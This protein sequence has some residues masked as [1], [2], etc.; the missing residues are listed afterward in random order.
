MDI[1]KKHGTL[2]KFPIFHNGTG[3]ASVIDLGSNSVK[4]V[5]YN[6]DS[7][8]SYKPYH[9]ESV[10][11][12][13][14]EGLVDGKIQEKYIENTI[15]T[16]KLFRNIVDFEQIDYLIA[17]ATSAV[18]DAKNRLEFLKRIK[19][20]TNFDFKILSE[21]EEALYSYTGAIRS[22]NLPSVVFFDIGGGSLE[23]VSSKNFEIQKVI[24]L[25]LGSL[26]LTQQFSNKSE[27][28][29][30]SI[31]KMKEYIVNLLPSRESLGILDYKDVIL[32]G[33][34]G[35][36]RAL[37]KYAQAKINY[38]LTKLHN[39]HLSFES[40]DAI[41]KE[42]LLQTNEK[43]TK[44][45]SIGSA[46]S[47]TIKAGSMIVSELMKKLEFSS[48][49]VSAQGLREGTLS[50]S[51]QYPE[52]FS[53]HNIER[54]HIQELIYLSCQPD[55]LS[56]HVEDLVHIFFSMNILSEHERIL[57]AQSIIQ[58]DN[59][60]SFRDVDNVLYTI[61]DNDSVLSHKEQLIVALSLIYSKKK[62]KAELLIT[63]FGNIL[64]QSDKKTI[65]KISTI[66]SLCDIF[67]KT[68]TLVKPKL[69]AF[70]S[71]HL[72]VFASKNTFPEILLKQACKKIENSLGI[73]IITS[74]YY[75]PSHNSDDKY[76]VTGTSIDKLRHYE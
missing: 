51:L 68:G 46:R 8:N 14:A 70:N 52:E 25:P 21:H 57:L 35:T 16:L 10:R 62:K 5:N 43:I 3:K 61:M 28:S 60:S 27:F 12:K 49:V 24:S 56:E 23:I 53:G 30:K 74:V 66:V 15:E 26:R 9:Q 13:L 18:R 54:E 2:K 32:V 45:D 36:I 72:E 41:R 59:L 22:L 76:L 50:L 17:V 20:E 58:I 7:T 44:I 69:D 37:A 55:V 48:L 65:K 39:Y 11:V 31:S 64:E 29:E 75:Q 38:P 6:V 19:K 34:G 4:M 47:D 63:R 40:L 33:V 73:S 42:L 71:L 67:H 1:L